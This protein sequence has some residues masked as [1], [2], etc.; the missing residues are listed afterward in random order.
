MHGRARNALIG[1]TLGI[2]LFVLIWYVRVHIGIVARADRSV[3]LGFAGLDRPA[4]NRITSFVANLCDPKPYVVLAAIPI[5]VALA[6][7][8]P[9][10]A[11]MIGVVILG[12]NATTQQLKPLLAE[13]TGSL[14]PGLGAASYPSGHAT[15]AMTLAL[16]SVIAVPA[17]WRPR[18]AASMA[19]FAVAVC[20][21][22]LELRWHYPSDVLGGFLMAGIWTLLGAAA[23]SVVDARW[24]QRVISPEARRAAPIPIAAALTPVAVVLLAAVAF[25]AL[26]AIVR[27]HAVVTYARAHEAFIFGAAA[28]GAM[29][30]LMATAA[31]LA[32][33]RDPPEA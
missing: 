27:P 21:S 1:A 22:F 17:R 3:L 2:A 16:C 6:R 19:A 23:L 4:V 14:I 10:V 29:S 11:A 31:M 9:R 26:L 8:R 18:V 5:L 24:P 7:R 30:L 25:A 15:A 20:Y 28:I 33:R 32:F 12:A 13:S